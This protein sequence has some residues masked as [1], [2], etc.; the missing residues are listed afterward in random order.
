MISLHQGWDENL[1]IQHN[2]ISQTFCIAISLDYNFRFNF[3]LTDVNKC[4]DGYL[5]IKRLRVQMKIKQEMH[6]HEVSKAIKLIS[7]SL[8]CTNTLSKDS[9]FKTGFLTRIGGR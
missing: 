5:N 8:R 1:N 9:I 3:I 7:C 6:E 2:T 4:M